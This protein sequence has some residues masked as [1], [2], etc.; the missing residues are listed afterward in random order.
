L[1]AASSVLQR[2]KK[3]RPNHPAGLFYYYFL[4]LKTL[5]LSLFQ[6]F[7]LATLAVYLRL[8][9]VYALLPLLVLAPLLSLDMVANERACS[10]PKTT[11]DQ[12]SARR[13]TDGGTNETTGGSTSNR[14]YPCCL[15]PR[16]QRT[17]GTADRGK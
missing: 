4:L 13:M 17:T 2:K 8:V 14:P 10:Q 9:L 16:G 15:F 5:V 6:P 12:G 3:A 7:S 1:N 11:T